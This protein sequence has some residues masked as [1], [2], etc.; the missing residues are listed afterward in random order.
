VV[1]CQGVQ[2]GA[3]GLKSAFV[4][5]ETESEDLGAEETPGLTLLSGSVADDS[6]TRISELALPTLDSEVFFPEL[7]PES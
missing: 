4:D 7:D 5:S 2:F 1:V 6:D 3:A